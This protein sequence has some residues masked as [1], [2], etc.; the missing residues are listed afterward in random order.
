MCARDVDSV[1]G[2]PVDS[3]CLRRQVVVA[4]VGGVGQVVAVGVGWDDDVEPSAG[5]EDRA[6]ED[7][8]GTVGETAD[9][10]KV[11]AGAPVADVVRRDREL[12]RLVEMPGRS[13][14]ARL[15]HRDEGG[16]PVRAAQLQPALRGP[17]R[18]SDAKTLQALK[19]LGNHL[20]S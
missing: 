6:G 12:A 3:V 7:L 2:E 14:H 15:L 4:G 8:V 11:L 1:Q 13:Q 10:D 20:G 5:V 18:E 19:R 17:P 9:P 16:L